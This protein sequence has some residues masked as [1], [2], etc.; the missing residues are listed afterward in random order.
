MVSL[1]YL[2]VQVHKLFHGLSKFVCPFQKNR[3]SWTIKVTP[4]GYLG[5]E[6]F[7]E[8]PYVAKL[9]GIGAINY[10]TGLIDVWERLFEMTD[11]REYPQHIGKYEKWI[12][13]H[14]SLLEKD[15]IICD[16]RCMQNTLCLMVVTVESE[17][18]A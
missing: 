8:G 17:V 18:G 10:I 11:E 3:L 2:G 6:A 9:S 15:G 5:R 7:K 4:G 14:E 1:Y 16:I 13:L 12:P